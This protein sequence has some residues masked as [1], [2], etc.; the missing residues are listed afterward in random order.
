MTFELTPAKARA[1]LEPMAE[2]NMMPLIEAIDPNV[3][4]TINTPDPDPECLTGVYVGL[5]QFLGS[6][7]C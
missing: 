4:W 7:S 2:G 3:H 6:N 5:S 1:L